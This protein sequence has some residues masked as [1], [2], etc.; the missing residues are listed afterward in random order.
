[1]WSELHYNLTRINSL[2]AMFE[3]HW[4]PI[5]AHIEYKLLCIIHK[6]LHNQ[7]SPAYL[8]DFVVS[9]KRLGTLEGLRSNRSENL[10][11]AP[12]VKY[13]TFV[14]RSFSVAGPRLWNNLSVDIQNTKLYDTFKT[15]NTL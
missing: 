3:L 12:F 1:M 10:L 6:C 4:L 2:K 15:I 9:N 14:W 5:K 7:Y 8:K 11:I 13:K